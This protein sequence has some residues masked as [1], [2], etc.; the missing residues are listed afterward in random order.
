M[1]HCNRDERAVLFIASSHSP[2]GRSVSFR[3]CRS[4]VDGLGQEPGNCDRPTTLLKCLYRWNIVPFVAGKSFVH[5]KEPP[6]L[7]S[8]CCTTF[9]YG[10]AGCNPLRG[11]PAR[12]ILSTYG[13]PTMAWV[14]LWVARVLSWCVL[15][16]CSR[17]PTA[18]T[19]HR[20]ASFVPGVVDSEPN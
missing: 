17:L 3:Y 5:L 12:E 4:V 8:P 7:F 10:V 6:V 9:H 20:L 1:K 13:L 18:H 16:S 14:E 2:N 15:I 11:S 19:M